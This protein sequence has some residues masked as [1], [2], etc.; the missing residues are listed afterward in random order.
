MLLPTRL[1]AMMHEAHRSGHHSFIPSFDTWWHGKDI[2]LGDAA[3]GSWSS[4]TKTPPHSDKD[5]SSS[6]S[7]VQGASPE[8]GAA[9]GGIAVNGGEAENAIK[10]FQERPRVGY[11][12]W[13][14][15]EVKEKET[16]KSP[17]V[18]VGPKALVPVGWWWT[19]KS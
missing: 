14:E 2:C 8:R 12:Q 10:Q 6:V 13:T 18:V 3:F 17:A 4:W 7:G 5:I 19:P 11:M 1:C 9:D 16:V 15:A